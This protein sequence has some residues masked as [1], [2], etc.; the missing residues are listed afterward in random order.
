MGLGCTSAVL[1][2]R[3]RFGVGEADDSAVEGNAAL[4]HGRVSS[5]SLSVRGFGDDE[6]SVGVPVSSCD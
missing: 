2:L 4:S 1:F 5:I 3:I 6:D